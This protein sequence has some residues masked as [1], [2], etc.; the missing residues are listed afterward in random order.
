MVSKRKDDGESLIKISET[1]VYLEEKH[2]RINQLEWIDLAVVKIWHQGAV[3]TSI[4]IKDDKGR[5]YKLK[6]E[7]VLE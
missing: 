6:G 7:M 2:L 1:A 3:V 5:V 4:E